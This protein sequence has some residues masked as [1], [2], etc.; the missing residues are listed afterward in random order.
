MVRLSHLSHLGRLSN[1][2]FFMIGSLPGLL[3]LIVALLAVGQI[4]MAVYVSVSEKEFLAELARV[5]GI[6]QQKRG[7]WSFWHK[8]L[9]QARAVLGQAELEGVKVVADTKYYTKQLEGVYEDQ[10]RA[11]TAR[12][13]AEFGKV[14]AAAEQEFGRTLAEAATAFAKRL[15]GKLEQENQSAREEIARYKK[16][17]MAEVQ[18]HAKEAFEE[19]GKAVIG[20][21]LSLDDQTELINQALEQ[22]KKEKF[23][24]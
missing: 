19:A 20:K 6:P 3:L 10:M 18:Q 1:L 7:M 22:A 17:V 24:T 21:S 8:S 23:I 11:A 16:A 5:L 14:I 2:S 15:E 13:E 12:M 9:K 4:V